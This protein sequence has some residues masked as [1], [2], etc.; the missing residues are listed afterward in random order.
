MRYEDPDLGGR[1]S[2]TMQLND[3]VLYFVK[4]Y[5]TGL[6]A[7]ARGWGRGNGRGSCL[8]GGGESGLG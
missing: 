1:A 6:G 2:T 7:A 3:P 8:G 5:W 4:L